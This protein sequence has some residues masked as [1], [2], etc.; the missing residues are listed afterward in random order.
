[1]LITSTVVPR[2]SGS[3]EAPS[4]VTVMVAKWLTISADSRAASSGCAVLTSC[5]LIKKTFQTLLWL[6]SYH[7]FLHSFSLL[8]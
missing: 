4:V 2:S 6:R 1:M 8:H 5:A 3:A 7:S